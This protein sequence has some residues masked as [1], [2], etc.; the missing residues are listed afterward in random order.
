M[1]KIKGIAEIVLHV[2]DMAAALKFYQEVL[3][4]EVLGRPGPVFLRAGDPAVSVPQMV[5]LVPLPAEAEPFAV[6]R[7]LHHLAL[8]LDPADFEAEEQRLKGLGYAIR[9]GQ[10]PVIPSRTMY[11]DDPEGNEVEFIC[12]Q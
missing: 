11:V 9:Y 4:L 10:H 2:H 6:P 5:V 3:G 8:E 7:P 1:T 12:G